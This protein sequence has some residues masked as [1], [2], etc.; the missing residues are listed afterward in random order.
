M[1]SEAKTEVMKQECRADF[2]DRNIREFHKQIQSHRME[3]D[4]T[5]VGDEQSRRE[6]ARLREELAERERALRETRIRRTLRVGKMSLNC[7]FGGR[8]NN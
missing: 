8:N 2:A 4:H 7:L 6:Q 5:N 1:L 3:I